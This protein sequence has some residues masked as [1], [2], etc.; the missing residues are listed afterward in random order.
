MKTA[1]I[2]NIMEL[3]VTLLVPIL[4]IHVILV[5]EMKFA[6]IVPVQ[7]FGEINAK[8]IAKIALAINAII[9]ELV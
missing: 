4:I 8:I 1:P 5:Q 2:T 7:N 9:M 6:L 3:T